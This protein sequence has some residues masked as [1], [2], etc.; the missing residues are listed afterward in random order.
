MIIGTY[1]GGSASAY[2]YT[3]FQELLTQLPDNTANQIEALNVRNSVYTLWQRIEDVRLI[4][5]QSASA[6]VYY[7]NLTPTPVTVGGISTGSTFINASMKDMWDKLLY[8]YI[9]PAVSLSPN[10]LREY[11]ATN[12]V[13]LSYSV[14]KNSNNIS[15]IIITQPN[16]VQYPIAGA[17]FSTS[18]SG[19]QSAFA[20]SNTNGTFTLAAND[21][22]NTS[23]TSVS[24]TWQSAIYWGTNSTNPYVGDGPAP[25]LTVTGTQPAW[26]TGASVSSGKGLAAGRTASVTG[27][28]PGVYDGIY[29]AG[30]YLVWA[31]PSTFGTPTFKVNGLTNTAFHKVYTGTHTNMNGYSVSY[32]IWMSDTKYNS[33]VGALQII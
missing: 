9:A 14:T 28:G 25:T 8:P 20:V 24:M 1:S 26:A 33:P 10:T 30:N 31:W 13:L 27:L 3:T 19:T 22:L 7:T 18:K 16:G 5:S 17:P 11:G 21:G 4:A 2:E 6:S 12:S 32:D 15:S 23:S 29:G